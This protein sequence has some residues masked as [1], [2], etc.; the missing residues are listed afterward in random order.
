MASRRDHP[1]S[2]NQPAGRRQ[3]ASGLR[4]CAA[5]QVAASPWASRPLW[6]S[7]SRP[8]RHRP[9]PPGAGVAPAGARS[10]SSRAPFNAAVPRNER[11]T[12]R[13][14]PANGWRPPAK[15]PSTAWGRQ[16]AGCPRLA[17]RPRPTGCRL[18]L[19][20]TNR[21]APCPP[22]W[23]QYIR[24]FPL[25]RLTPLPLPWEVCVS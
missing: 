7:P 9:R 8:G 23:K 11:P 21:P 2:S 1:L 6:G 5:Q 24:Q 20:G 12:H 19:E 22:S 25:V 18:P 3:L 10:D 14:P 13:P 15:R 17:G 4:T 16:P